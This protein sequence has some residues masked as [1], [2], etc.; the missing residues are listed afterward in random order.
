MPDLPDSGAKVDEVTPVKNQRKRKP[1]RKGPH[2]PKP[3][4]VTEEDKKVVERVIQQHRLEFDDEDAGAPTNDRGKYFQEK[5]EEMFKAAGDKDAFVASM[6]K[7]IEMLPKRGVNEKEV[8][9]R[10]VTSEVLQDP[11]PKAKRRLGYEEDGPSTPRVEESNTL[12][13]DRAPEAQIT[14]GELHA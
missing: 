1:Q 12:S 4:I 6:M 11:K 8:D 14:E 2:A 5:L 10:S 3:R 13:C 9:G 7:Q